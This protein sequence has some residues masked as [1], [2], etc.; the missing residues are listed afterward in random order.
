ME[1]VLRKMSIISFTVLCRCCC[2]RYKGKFCCLCRRLNLLIIELFCG[3]ARD[4]FVRKPL[5]KIKQ[6]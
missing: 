3:K 6:N 4:I 2:N 1:P 5:I